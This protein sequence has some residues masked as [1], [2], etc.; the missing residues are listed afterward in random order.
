MPKLKQTVFAALAV[1]IAASLILLAPA[2][3]AAGA[4]AASQTATAFAITAA[5]PAVVKN[6]GFEDSP[7]GANWTQGGASNLVSD[8]AKHS[9]KYAAYLGGIANTDHSI[10]QKITLPARRPLRVSFWWS[11]TTTQPVMADFDTLTVRL[12]KSDG[13]SALTTL[14]VLQ[15][16]PEMTTWDRLEYDLSAYS[17]QTVWLEFR[18]TNDETWETHFFVDDVVVVGC[19][20]YLTITTR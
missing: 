11:Q 6:G 17:G 20:Q 14:G 2:G 3:P 7:L 8:F 18:A 13:A 15:A 9:G 19:Y 1:A 16:D 10:K 5:C 4:P 12:L